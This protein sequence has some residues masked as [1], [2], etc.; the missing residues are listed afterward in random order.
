VQEQPRAGHVRIDVQVLDSSRIERRCAPDHPVNFVALAD[1]EL[2]EVGAVLT[3]NS[4][5]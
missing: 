4:G 1:Q 5:D 2:G 3:G